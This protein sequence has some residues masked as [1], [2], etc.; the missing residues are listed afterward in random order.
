MLVDVANIDNGIRPAVEI[1]VKHGFDTFES[2]EGGKDHAMPEPTI[3]FYGSEFDLM[4]AYDICSHYRLNILSVRRV[5]DKEQINPN[6]LNDHKNI[7]PS[8][9]AWAKPYNEIVFIK[10]AETGTIFLPH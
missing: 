1:M 8:G 10:H 6:D 5:Y 4:R 3:K 9:Y 7:F 2:C